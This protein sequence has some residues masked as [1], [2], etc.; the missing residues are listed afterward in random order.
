MLCATI[1]AAFSRAS[2]GACPQ[3]K[4]CKANKCEATT[5]VKLKKFGE[6]CGPSKDCQPPPAGTASNSPAQGAYRDCLNA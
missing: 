2:C 6:W 3:G 4:A 5:Q 1:Q